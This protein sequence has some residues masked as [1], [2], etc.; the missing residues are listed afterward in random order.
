M[1]VTSPGSRRSSLAGVAVAALVLAG[2][3]ATGA[4]WLPSNDATQKATFGFSYDGST[5]S[6]SGSYHDPRGQ[7]TDP[8]DGSVLGIV[9]VDLK[10]TGRLHPCTPSDCRAA[11]PTKGGCVFGEPAYQ[12]QNRRLP[13][14]GVMFLEVCDGDGVDATVDDDFVLLIVETGPY[15]G[16][17]NQGQP[18][19]NTSV[20]S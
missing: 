11:P 1:R 16:Y 17:R 18:S 7:V 3:T 9:D 13:G 8:L 4:G 20:R 15:T 5:S 14:S 19:G 6:L 10:G 12:S 2:C